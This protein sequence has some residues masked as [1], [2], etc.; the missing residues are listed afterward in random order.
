[1]TVICNTFS[2][3][4]PSLNHHN[5]TLR[6]FL[7]DIFCDFRTYLPRM[8]GVVVT[9]PLNEAEIMHV[10]FVDE[11][12]P[13]LF[14]KRVPRTNRAKL[15]KE[16]RKNLDKAEKKISLAFGD[17][18]EFEERNIIDGCIEKYLK[19]F[20][21]NP[22]RSN[23]DH[24]Q[25]ESTCVF[26]SSVSGWE[27]ECYCELFG[28]VRV[29]PELRNCFLAD[30][31]YRCWISVE[32]TR[33][34]SLN[35]ELGEY[36]D[37][38]E[39]QNLV[40]EAP[41]NR[42]DLRFVTVVNSDT[43][44][45]DSDSKKIVPKISYPY[46]IYDVQ[47]VLVS[48]RNVYS[49][50]YPDMKIALAYVKRGRRTPVGSCI[51]FNAYYSIPLQL[52]VVRSYYLLEKSFRIKP[53][54]FGSL[55]LLEVCAKWNPNLP[56]GHLW[57]KDKDLGL[58][59]DADGLL[60]PILLDKNPCASVC[61]YVAD[62]GPSCLSRFAVKD[63][64]DITASKTNAIMKNGYAEL[65]DDGLILGD[66]S[67]LACRYL[68]LKIFFD[69]N[70]PKGWDKLTPGTWIK[71]TA[72]SPAGIPNFKIKTW[73]STN[74]PHL[75]QIRAVPISSGY[76]FET[77]TY[78]EKELSA[79]KSDIFGFIEIPRKKRQLMNPKDQGITMLWVREDKEDKRNKKARF[80]F[81]SIDAPQIVDSE[82][83]T[84]KNST[85][86]LMN[87]VEQ[88]CITEK[89][90]I[91]PCKSIECEGKQLLQRCFNNRAIVNSLIQASA[92]ELI[93]NIVKLL[94]S[95]KSKD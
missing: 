84:G 1:M 14:I 33:I 38:S 88:Y 61:V 26:P 87:D 18:I 13:L 21:L 49:S 73:N 39:D 25:I 19:I 17:W 59:Y 89:K 43:D 83:T 64:S 62:T 16:E 5:L 44:E 93:A 46:E 91:V 95:E 54:E 63:L 86:P 90:F 11:R 68:C 29:D 2:L 34:S 58:I 9:P 23:G 82:K 56:M 75:V 12:N 22:C 50:K 57:S 32:V 28:K 70:S 51:N 8:Y 69:N 80:V 4:F 15:T 41:W 74:N 20:P 31:A 72:Q 40:D 77:R 65:S 94:T 7:Q 30:V 60:L 92:D 85:Q 24:L 47:G 42:G 27:N 55:F 79:A 53:F 71:F 36:I 66:G 3:V 45:S 48:E 76:A 78:F 35:V 81:H 10:V 6:I 67:V 37:V 52:Y